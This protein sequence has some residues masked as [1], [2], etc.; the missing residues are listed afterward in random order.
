MCGPDRTC[1]ELLRA[2]LHRS[3]ALVSTGSFCQCGD[4]RLELRELWRLHHESADVFAVG[5]PVAFIEDNAVRQHVLTVMNL[6]T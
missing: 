5:G 6:R 1:V 2:E 3:D 4:V